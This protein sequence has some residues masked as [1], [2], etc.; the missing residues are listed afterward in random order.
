MHQVY[1]CD[2]HGRLQVRMSVSVG[3]AYRGFCHEFEF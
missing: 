3:P 1:V 2:G